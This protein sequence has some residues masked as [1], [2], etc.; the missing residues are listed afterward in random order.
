GWYFPKAIN[1]L[2]RP[3]ADTREQTSIR[4]WRADISIHFDSLLQYSLIDQ[5]IVENRLAIGLPIDHYCVSTEKF[6]YF[7]RTYRPKFDLGDELIRK[8]KEIVDVCE[9]ILDLCGVCGT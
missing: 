4:A 6:L 7:M 1:L 5:K 3:I 2:A 9:R 8:D